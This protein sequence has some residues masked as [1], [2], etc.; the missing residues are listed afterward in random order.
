ML[1]PVRRLG[2]GEGDGAVSAIAGAVWIGVALFG[3]LTIS[4]T[5]LLF[6]M[7]CDSYASIALIFL[8][9]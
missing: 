5:L 9:I 6:Q 8:A 2:A 4:G 1:S 3:V 7:N